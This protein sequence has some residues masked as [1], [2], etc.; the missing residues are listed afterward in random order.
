MVHYSPA[1]VSRLEHSPGNYAQA[2]FDDY[3][4]PELRTL[5]Y[6]H[7]QINTTRP[8]VKEQIDLKRVCLTLLGLRNLS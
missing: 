4:Y 6:K 2:A 7:L 1:R 8:Y 3:F 5:L